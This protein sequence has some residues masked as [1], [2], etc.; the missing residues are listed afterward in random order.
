[1]ES[2]GTLEKDGSKAW[3]GVIKGRFLFPPLNRRSTDCQVHPV[4]E[5][6][7]V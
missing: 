6:Y 7:L 5:V 4:E 3:A 1:M 2:T